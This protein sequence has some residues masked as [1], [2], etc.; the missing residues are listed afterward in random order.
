[1]PHRRVNAHSAAPLCGSLACHHALRPPRCTSDKS[2][3]NGYQ[4]GRIVT[5]N[6]FDDIITDF[7]TYFGGTAVAHVRSAVATHVNCL[8][9]LSC[10]GWKGDC[11]YLSEVGAEYQGQG[12]DSSLFLP[13]YLVVLGRITA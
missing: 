10:A 2:N 7:V 1:M 11:I 8:A 4:L 13:C 12:D 9:F 6:M 5:N 3:V